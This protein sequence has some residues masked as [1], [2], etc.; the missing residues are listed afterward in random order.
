MP[1]LCTYNTRMR[2]SRLQMIYHSLH[3][4]FLHANL[5]EKVKQTFPKKQLEEIGPKP[6]LSA[7]KGEN[8]EK[9]RLFSMDSDLEAFSHYPTDVS[10]AALTFQLTAFTKYLIEQ[11]LSY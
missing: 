7:L 2:L 5:M 6:I 9:H 4:L 11:F 8:G 10:F 1:T 3:L